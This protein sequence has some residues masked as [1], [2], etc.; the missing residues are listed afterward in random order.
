MAAPAI[1]FAPEL[2][3]RHAPLACLDD[4]TGLPALLA[5]LQLFLQP[6]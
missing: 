6:L 3:L 2:L 1:G 5:S 4:I